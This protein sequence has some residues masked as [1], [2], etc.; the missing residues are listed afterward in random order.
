MSAQHDGITLGESL[1]KMVSCLG[2]SLG[3]TTM[4]YPAA[5]VD[6]SRE[7][8]SVRN[9]KGV[10]CTLC[11]VQEAVYLSIIRIIEVKK[12]IGITEI[13]STSSRSQRSTWQ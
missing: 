3:C 4:E 6:V 10:T 1:A 13:P 9:D 2:F 12:D 11:L 7:D 5:T 8:R